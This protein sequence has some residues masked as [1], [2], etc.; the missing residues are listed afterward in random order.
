MKAFIKKAVSHTN[1]K[2]AAAFLLLSVLLT[3]LEE[4]RP[5]VGRR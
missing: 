3:V 1:V 4:V 5:V 2:E